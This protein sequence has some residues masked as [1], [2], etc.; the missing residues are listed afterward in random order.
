MDLTQVK[1]CQ[2]T[3]SAVACCQLRMWSRTGRHT[4]RCASQLQAWAKASAEWF[5]TGRRCFKRMQLARPWWTS[6][7]RMAWF[8]VSRWT[9]ATTRS[10]ELLV[11]L[12]TNA[13][14]S[15][16]YCSQC[17]KLLVDDFFRGSKKLTNT[18]R[19]HGAGIYANIGEYY[20]DGIHV[21]IYSRHGS[22]GIW[23]S[24]WSESTI[25]GTVKVLPIGHNLDLMIHS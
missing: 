15:I 6:S 9:R 20:I 23:K 17:L 12:F 8:L 13:T 18:H 7:R 10:L 5:S 2:Q 19:I 1:A 21:A 25:G 16:Q 4:D 22:Y 24:L 3:E 14:Y 11:F